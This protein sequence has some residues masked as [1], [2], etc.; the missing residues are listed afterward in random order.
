MVHDEFLLKDVRSW[1]FTIIHFVVN[2][3]GKLSRQKI[4]E[5]MVGHEIFLKYVRS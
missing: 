4:H 1:H 5:I 2:S 3:Y